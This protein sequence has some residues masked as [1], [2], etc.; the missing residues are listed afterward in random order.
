MS[1]RVNLLPQEAAAKQEAARQ[2]GAFMVA[3]VVLLLLLGLLYWWQLARVGDARDERD[4]AQEELQVLQA[5]EA[6]LAEFGDLENRVDEANSIIETALADEISY[7]GVLQDLAAVM[8][9]DSALTE[10]DITAVEAE[11]PD[12]GQVRDVIARIVASGESLEGHAPGLERLLLEM[13]KIVSFFDVYFTSSVVDG[14]DEDVVLFDFEVDVGQEAR[15]GRYEG[16][17]PEELR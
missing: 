3:G 8:P 9:A 2:R 15:T 7:A 14:D 13:D 4:L 1:V 16:G 6:Q 5:R 12:G 11:G 17:V 10:F